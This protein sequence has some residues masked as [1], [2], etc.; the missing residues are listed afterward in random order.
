MA[1]Q[2]CSKESQKACFNSERLFFRPLTAQD[3]DLYFSLYTDKQVMR[4]I[5]PPFNHEQAQQLFTFTLNNSNS[6]GDLRLSW[7]IIEIDSQKSIGI[8]ALTW[9]L[10]QSNTASIGIMLSPDSQ[11]KGFGLEAQGALIEYG[12]TQLSLRRIYSQFATSNLAN[13]HIY[14]ELGFVTDINTNNSKT[15]SNQLTAISCYLEKQAWQHNFI[16]YIPD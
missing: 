15:T 3:K 6:Y 2:I 12:F 4:Y 9:D 1:N 14:N 11:G 5:G 10:T 16:Q 13:K 8:L 7:T